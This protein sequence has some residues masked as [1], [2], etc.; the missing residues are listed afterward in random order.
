MNQFPQIATPVSYSLFKKH[1]HL[2]IENSD[3]LEG[4]PE[5]VDNKFA[6][7]KIFHCDDVE[8]CHELKDSEFKKIKK[9]IDT[10]PEL[11]AIS[12]HVA[13]C[14]SYSRECLYSNFKKN[15]RDIRN[16]VGDKQI[17]IENNNYFDEKIHKHV[18]DGDFLSSLVYDNDIFFLLDISHAKITSFYK[19]INYEDYLNSLPLDKCKQIHLSRINNSIPPRDSHLEPRDKEIKEVIK[20]VKAYKTI[21]YLTIECYTNINY[22]IKSIKR[23]KNSLKHAGLR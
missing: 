19:Q 17:L 9:I 16:I 1:K 10:K 3:C 12:F 4:R 6:V 20:L 23:L 2:I 11:K 5:M 15:I 13:F 22:L 14:K 7:E 18:T 21:D 8:P